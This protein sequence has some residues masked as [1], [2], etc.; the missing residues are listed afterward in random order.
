M[1]QVPVAHARNPSYSGDRDHEDRGLKPAQTNSSRDP[2]SEKAHHKKRAGGVVQGI[3]PKFKKNYNR[4]KTAV[5]LMSMSTD[6]G[7]GVIMLFC[8]LLG[9]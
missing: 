6:F 9:L 4:R 2:I 7:G 5:V 8:V 3:G 1:S